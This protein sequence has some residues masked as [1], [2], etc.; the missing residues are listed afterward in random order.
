VE[1][2]LIPICREISGRT[3]NGKNPEEN[4]ISRLGDIWETQTDVNRSGR[5]VGRRAASIGACEA[6]PA[7]PDG[8]GAWTARRE[9]K[10]LAGRNSEW[11]QG[12]GLEW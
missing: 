1:D 2:G 5:R 3:E 11:C 4:A 7:G 12:G 8:R 9:S 6:R 10:K